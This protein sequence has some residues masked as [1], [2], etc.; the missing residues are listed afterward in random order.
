MKPSL[1]FINTRMGERV[2]FAAS[3]SLLILGTVCLC[4][5]KDNLILPLDFLCGFISFTFLVAVMGIKNASTG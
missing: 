2:T 3:L 1:D 4:S 5:M